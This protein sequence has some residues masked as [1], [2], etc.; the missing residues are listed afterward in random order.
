VCNLNQTYSEYKRSLTFRVR[1]F[2]L[3]CYSNET[4]A[5]IAT[6]SNSAQIGDPKLHP[7]QCSSVGMRP[8]TDTQDTQ[9]RVININFA[10]STTHA[11]CINTDRLEELQRLG[12]FAVVD[13][14]AGRQQ[15]QSV[16]ELE[17]GKTRLMNREDNCSTSERQSNNTR[18][19]HTG[20]NQARSK[21]LLLRHINH[22]FHF[23]REELASSGG[24]FNC[25]IR[26]FPSTTV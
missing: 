5:P 23:M 7:G 10:S 8:R 12:G 1:N 18:Y 20:H 14:V 11:N 21:C 13:C 4:R 26:S 25:V 15:R 17:D 3:C 6:R 9:T 2:A 19:I 24:G 16:K 22:S